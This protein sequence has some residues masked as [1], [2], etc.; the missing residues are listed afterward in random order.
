MKVWGCKGS[1]R[2]AGWAPDGPQR[3]RRWDLLS[4]DVIKM[5]K[6]KKG[7]S[8]CEKRWVALIT[9][10]WPVHQRLNPPALIK[11]ARSH[12]CVPVRLE[13]VQHHNWLSTSLSE[14]RASSLL[15]LVWNRGFRACH[16]LARRFL[17]W[18]LAKGVHVPPSFRHVP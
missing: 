6:K 15:L 1:S 4:F 11:A 13:C 14:E 10:T 8:V 9:P 3:A 7:E 16:I 12:I 18:F 2:A 5:K 17:V